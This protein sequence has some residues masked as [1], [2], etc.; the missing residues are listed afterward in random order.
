MSSYFVVV[1]VATFVCVAVAC[2]ICL[3]LIENDLC[4][5][6]CLGGRV[7]YVNMKIS[8]CMQLHVRTDVPYRIARPTLCQRIFRNRTKKNWEE[9][10]K[11][12]SIL[13]TILHLHSVNLCVK[14]MPASSPVHHNRIN[15]LSLTCGARCWPCIFGIGSKIQKNCALIEM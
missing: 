3:K 4:G 8:F 10:E 2:T 7:I 12:E 15:I 9:K 1:F 13:A 6:K 11:D 14:P 5:E